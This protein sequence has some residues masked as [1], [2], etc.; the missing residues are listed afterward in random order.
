M[1]LTREARFVVACVCEPVEADASE[2]AVAASVVTDWERVAQLAVTPWMSAFV[3]LA[4]ARAAISL[5]TAA[6]QVLREAAR[7]AIA[8]K[9][10]LDAEL[11]RV[12]ETFAAAGLPVIVLKGLVLA[13]TIYAESALRPYSDI[14]LSVPVEQEGAAAALL[15]QLGLTEVPYEAEEARRAHGHV[16]GGRPF[17]ASSSDAGAPRWSNSTR[18]RSSLV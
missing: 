5:P 3:R 11:S 1:A 12:L 8:R 18:I 10:Q 9:L 13:R 16:H 2:V 4:I 14:D 17:T 15:E 6:E 7:V